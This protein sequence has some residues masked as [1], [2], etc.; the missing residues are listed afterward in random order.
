MKKIELKFVNELGRIVTY[1]L[2]K[3]IEPV[4]P[5]LVKQV[6]DEIITQN[7]FTSTGGDLVEKHSARL[8]ENKVEE[9]DIEE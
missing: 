6:M 5:T 2:E 7:I 3:P 9:I 1:S 4:D 8:V